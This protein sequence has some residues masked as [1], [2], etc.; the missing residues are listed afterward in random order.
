[1][2]QVDQPTA[3]TSLPAPSVA[4]TQGYFTG[5]NPGT[6]TPATILDADFMNMVMME[7]TNIVTAGGLTPSKTTYNQVLTAIMSLT[8][9]GSYLGSK[10]FSSSGTYTPGVYNGV[11]ATKAHFRGVASGGG[12][13]GCIATAAGQ[14]AASAGGSAGNPFDFW[15]VSGLA[16]MSITIGAAGAAG[17]AGANSGGNGGNLVI[18]SIATITGGRGG[19]AGNASGTFPALSNPCFNNAASTI[20]SAGGM[21]VSSVI[22]GFG[23][24]AVRGIMLNSGTILYSAGGNTAWGSGGTVDQ[25]P[26]LGIGSGAVG[27]GIGAS[28]AATA[29]FSGA[30]G[31]L[32]IDEYA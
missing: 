21:T 30:L 22:N 25:A 29:G 19:S 9:R 11:T 14:A 20:A 7:L 3:A 5:G 17:A 8:G 13:G 23:Q 28:T 26:A 4:G 2:F 10:G 24:T 12:S 18:G 32:I 1:M 6:G 31:I 15:V 16:A 27:N